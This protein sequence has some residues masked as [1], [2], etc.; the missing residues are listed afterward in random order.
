MAGT[1]SGLMRTMLVKDIP[2]NIVPVDL[3][4]CGLI[5]ALWDIAK[6]GRVR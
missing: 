4:I 2:A 1:T 3:C 5:A 6:Q